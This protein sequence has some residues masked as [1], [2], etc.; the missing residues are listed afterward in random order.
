M[1]DSRVS[2]CL[3]GTEKL[4]G[5]SL[6]IVILAQSPHTEVER[7]SINYLSVSSL[8]ENNFESADVKQEIPLGVRK[9]NGNDISMR[10]SGDMKPPPPFPPCQEESQMYPEESASE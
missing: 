8:L 6:D 7:G 4:F 9:V 5:Q 3:V 10:V 2:S 1:K